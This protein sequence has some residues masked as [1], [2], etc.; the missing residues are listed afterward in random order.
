MH[1]NRPIPG[2]DYWPDQNEWSNDTPPKPPSLFI[3]ALGFI[4]LFILFQASW[5]MVRDEAIGHFVRGEITVKPA[6]KLIN[7][8]SPEI[9]AVANG[10]QIKASGGGLVIKIGCEGVEALF[11]LMAALLTANMGWRA[12]LGGILIGTAFVY[13]FNQA[14]IL[15]L[16]YAFRM[17]KPFFYFL[18]GAVAPLAL[19]GLAGLFFN[20]WL[21]KYGAINS[22]R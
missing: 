7:I 6:V 12:K 1:K 10:N 13:V 20:Y 2:V 3:Q 14:R 16:F 15:G 18:H 17:D 21:I 11:I 22:V 19:I 8:L 5:Q 4:I 9:G